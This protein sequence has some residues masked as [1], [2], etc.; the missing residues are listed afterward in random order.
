M[1]VKLSLSKSRWTLLALILSAIGGVALFNNC[2]RY[3]SVNSDTLHTSN[4]GSTKPTYTY[5]E[6]IRPIIQSRCS[7]CH[8]AGGMA[9][10]T[11]SNYTQ[12][13]DWG[14]IILSR[15]QARSMPPWGAQD[16]GTCQSFHSSLW[17]SESEI[18]TYE[19]WVDEKFP[20]GEATPDINPAPPL[21]H[22]DQSAQDVIEY[23]MPSTY[24]PP[25]NND[26]DDYR[27]FVT[28]EH[29]S[30]K[31]IIGFDVI[32]GNA[33]V[34]HHI[35]AYMPSSET[36]E[37]Q[38]VSKGQG[39]SCFGGPGVGASVVA[40]WAPGT[41]ITPYPNVVDPINPT[42]PAKQTGLKIP[43]GRKLILQVH[44]NYASGRQSDQSAVRF[45]VAP[46][47]LTVKEGFWFAFGKTSGAEVIPKA[48]QEYL[49]TETIQ[50]GQALTGVT[51]TTS[52]PG[53]LYAVFPH[54][55]Q[56][57]SKINMEVQRAS[58]VN[59]SLASKECLVK[60]PV[61]DFHWQRVYWFKKPV[62]LNT[63]DTLQMN[64]TYSTLNK[65]VDTHFGEGSLDEMCFMFGFVTD[66]NL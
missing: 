60:V 47:S 40:F 65:S 15:L 11:L 38:A 34:V 2:G 12:V 7:Q 43:A 14:K 58:N 9:P 64:C 6:H 48:T 5:G 41:E 8:Q 13:K 36:E 24:V 22:Y 52:T 35:I 29:N 16:D 37:T 3:S 19:T 33:N 63:L 51:A 10:F 18:A 57:G 25:N 61:W 20:E 21:T 54:M 31:L 28:N 4:L 23:S 53:Y 49:H 66:A 44:Y 32:P 59:N 39:Y 50:M 55:H 26:V 56:V 30:N 1:G 27:C 17:M 42:K 45:K 46:S 62:A